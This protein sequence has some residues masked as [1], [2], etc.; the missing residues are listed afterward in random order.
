MRLF[1]FERTVKK[2]DVKKMREI[3]MKRKEEQKFTL[4]PVLKRNESAKI[5]LEEY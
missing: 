4:P 1:C 5:S 3:S 2:D